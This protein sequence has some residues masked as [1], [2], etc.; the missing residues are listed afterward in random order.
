M[1]FFDN[2]LLENPPLVKFEKFVDNAPTLLG[3]FREGVSLKFKVTLSRSLGVSYPKLLLWKDEGEKSVLDFRF[4]YFQGSKDTFELTLPSLEKG[5]WFYTL[6]FDSLYFSSINNLDFELKKEEYTPFTLLIYDKDFSTPEFLK[7]GIM[8]HI[9]V[10]RFFRGKGEVVFHGRLV[11]DWNSIPEYQ[12]NIGD[13]LKNDNF[14]GGNL[15]GVIEKLDFLKS[16]S[17]DILYLSPIFSSP[18]NH[19]YDTSDYEEVDSTLGGN[20]AFEILVKEAHKRKMKVILDGVFNHT[21]SDS[22]YFN[23]K[24]RFSEIGAFQSKDSPYFNWYNFFDFP[25]DYECWWGIKILPRLNHSYTPCFEYFSKKI[26]NKWIELGADGWRLDVADELSN[27]FLKALRT[28][29]KQ[30]KDCAIIGEVWENAVTKSAYGERKEYF[31]GEELDSVMNYPLRFAILDLLINEDTTLFYNTV[32][33]LYTSYPE[34]VLHS[35]MNILST[36]DTERTLTLLGD[37]GKNKDKDNDALAD[38]TLTKEERE[39]GIRLMKIAAALQYTL[40]G[41]PSVYYGDENGMEGYRDPFCRRGY[42]WEKKEEELLSYYE[43]LGKL[44]KKHPALK[45]GTFNF[46]YIDKT[47][48]SYERKLDGDCIKVYVNIGEE[49]SVKIFE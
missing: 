36:H 8:Y 38:L 10:D 18:S 30:T 19:R 46:L 13:D 40:F 43:Y 17:V 4:L 44:R 42:N 33:E 22:R 31:W 21:G 16:L 25:E 39:N 41:F 45:R 28:N 29:A 27:R 3:A 14:Y 47:S 9:F 23:K 49:K 48:F 5:L 15:W 20:K 34:E 26:V 24:G 11:E 1:L 32:T 35:L 37:K 7:G 2:K 6:D 12:K